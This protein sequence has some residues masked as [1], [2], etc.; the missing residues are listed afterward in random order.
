MRSLKLDSLQQ[1]PREVGGT[2][3]FCFQASSSVAV[4]DQDLIM[5][6]ALEPVSIKCVNRPFIMGEIK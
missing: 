6:Q 2:V 4:R 1:V 5:T 3:D